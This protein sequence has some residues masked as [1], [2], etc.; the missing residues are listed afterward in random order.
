MRVAVD[1]HMAGQPRA[2]D[3]GNARYAVGL[4]AALAATAGPGDDA[5]AL[6]AHPGG[7]AQLPDGVPH[8]SVGAGNAPRLLRRAPRALAAIGADAAVFTYIAPPRPGV[9]VAL[10]VHDASFVTHPEWLAPRA[11]ML[12]RELVPR[13]ARRADAVLALS[14]TAAAEIATALRVPDA[15]VHVVTP[16]PAA[17]FGPRPG[18]EERVASRFG[19]RRYCLAVGDLGPRKNLP[20]LADALGRL[21]DPGLELVLAGR[22]AGAE[23][24]LRAAPRVRLLGRVSDDDLADL[25]AAAAVTAFP[26]LH[27]GFGL[28]AVEAMACGSPLVVSD[29]GALPE[30]VG[31]AALIAAPT[32]SGIAD[33]LR[34]ALEPVTGERLRAAGPSRAAAFTLERM[35]REG[36]TA[37]GRAGR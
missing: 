11:R 23:G 10:A 4:V 37:L 6:V 9:P 2:G 12:L 35:G 24:A 16:A 17:A 15:R 36:W 29:R 7:I 3:A 31:D 21:A 20:A 30:V 28:P 8:A 18:A 19:L 34:A 32:P 1:C 25:Y 27:E 14:A 33:A 13:S 26:S 5:W 22:P